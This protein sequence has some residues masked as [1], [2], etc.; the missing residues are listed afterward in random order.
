MTTFFNGTLIHDCQ[1]SVGT[2]AAGA[3]GSVHLW[4]EYYC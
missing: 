3:A 4:P 2:L 1:T